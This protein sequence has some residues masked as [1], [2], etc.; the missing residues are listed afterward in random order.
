VTLAEESVGTTAPGLV[1]RTGQQASVLGS[2]HYFAGVKDMF[3]AAAPIRGVDGQL[4]GILDISSEMVPF[5]FDPSVLVSAYASSIENRLL[6]LQSKNTIV[7]KFQF[8]PGLIDSP[9]V[10]MLGIN[11]DGS[12]IWINSAA[13]SLLKIPFECQAENLKFDEIFDV[14]INE[15]LQLLGK[16]PS[17]QR[18]PNGFSV[19]LSANL[20][21]RLLDRSPDQ[22]AVMK[23]KVVLDEDASKVI[24]SVKKVES[25]LTQDKKMSEANSVSLRDADAE[26][27]KLYLIEYRGNISKVAKRLQVSRGLIYRRMQDL[28]IDP[29]LYK[30]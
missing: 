22:K 6:L 2:E 19:Y 28:A 5:S 27:I 11:F 29:D 18:L 14:R 4:A 17:I 1:A 21:E 23:S 24:H 16:G 12:I 9:L 25:D 8:L 30:K 7:V 13:N 20:S 10:G 3:C 26:L 15:L